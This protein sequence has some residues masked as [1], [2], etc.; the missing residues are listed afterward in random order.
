MKG[1]VKYMQEIQ[2]LTYIIRNLN[3]Y[4]VGVKLFPYSSAKWAGAIDT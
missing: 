3:S 1:K 2:F 4:E